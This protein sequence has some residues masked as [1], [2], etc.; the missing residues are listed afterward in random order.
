MPICSNALQP[1]NHVKKLSAFFILESILTQESM[2]LDRRVFGSHASKH[3]S[4]F[5]AKDYECIFLNKAD[6]TQLRV[7]MASIRCLASV[8]KWGRK[9]LGGKQL[10]R[11]S[12]MFR[13]GVSPNHQ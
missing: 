13:L 4:G 9:W 5:L 7:Y 2:G 3:C 6:K 11:E 12:F 8:K 1:V 10:P